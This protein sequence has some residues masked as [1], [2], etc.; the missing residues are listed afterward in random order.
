M[1]STFIR[2]PRGFILFLCLMGI[3]AS[4]QPLPP[5]TQSESRQEETREGTP[6]EKQ[7]EPQQPQEEPQNQPTV[8][9]YEPHRTLSSQENQAQTPTEP[10]KISLKIK[11]MDV[12]EVFNIL[13]QK[14]KLNIIAGNDVRGRVTMFIENVDIWTAFRL[15]VETNDLAY[16]KDGNVIRVFTDREYELLFGRKFNDKT[17][18]RVFQL[19]QTS[20]EQLKPTLDGMKSKI[21]KIFVDENSNSFIVIDAEPILK[22]IAE[23]IGSLDV[24][25]KTEI[26]E[27]VYTDPKSVEERLKPFLTKRGSIQI[28]PLTNK[29]IISDVPST[30]EVI[31]RLIKEYDVA[32]YVKTEV[33]NL[34][35]A[36]FDE[37]KEK[38]EKE[39]TEGIGY[40]R[41]DERTNKIAI[42]DLPE[43]LER[44]RKIIEAFDDKHREVLIQ[45]Q[46]VQVHLSKNFKYGINWEYIATAIADHAMNLNLSSGFEVLSE[47]PQTDTSQI[48]AFNQRIPTRVPPYDQ[49]AALHPAGRVILAGVADGGNDGLGNPY[50]AVLD[51]LKKTGDIDILSTPRITVLNN[52]EAKIQVGTNEAYV[53]NT[54]VQNTTNATT[55]ENVNF[56]QVGVILKVKPLINEEGYIT[57]EIEPEVSSV[58]N[59]LVTASGNRI[60]IVRTS[61]AKT[62]VMVKDGVTIV[63]GG[64]IDR[65][66]RKEVSK[67]P[68]L[69][70]IPIIGLPF[71][72]IEN[73]VS[74]S[75]LVIFLTPRIITGD[76]E[77]EEKE[78]F[79]KQ[80]K[81]PAPEEPGVV[82]DVK[83]FVT[84]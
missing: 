18:V 11:N 15:I 83:D 33:F 40:I 13:N 16:A 50:Q 31:K 26:Y 73:E 4:A 57:M 68:I 9:A 43:K 55:A 25:L 39:I 10:G 45:A 3:E 49:R 64:L 77:T 47:M 14:G 82:N 44:M 20:T 21:G 35:Y 76:V 61:N 36:K 70:S 23:A 59:F 30:F 22:E 65:T 72:K 34:K 17:H 75:E 56:I 74:N 80:L 60:P 81:E 71:K 78:H 58:S 8:Q 24:P 12:I 38:I 46:I 27:L 48:P 84:S 63:I 29:I 41:A 53:T 52:E 42:T 19:K 1:R 66:T 51:L 69:G 2:G 37:V 6:E 67:I 28:D 79:Q 32:P 7:E 5:Q 54:V 62:R